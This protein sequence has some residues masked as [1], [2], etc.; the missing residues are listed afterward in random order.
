MVV[1]IIWVMCFIRLV[2]ITGKGNGQL[3]ILKA[4][5][6]STQS[7]IKLFSLAQRFLWNVQ[8]MISIRLSFT[9]RF[10]RYAMLQ[11]NSSGLAIYIHNES[12]LHPQWRADVPLLF[13]R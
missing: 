3:N 1:L 8:D 6:Q 12:T 7:N 5:A 2:S 11:L 10:I 13:F 4:T 9:E